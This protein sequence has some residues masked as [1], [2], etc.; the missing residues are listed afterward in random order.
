MDNLAFAI[1]KTILNG[2]ERHIYLFSEITQSAKQRFEQCQW[3]EVQVAAKARTDFYDQRVEETL[4]TLQ[5]DFFIGELKDDLWQAVK[6]SYVE[7]LNQHPQPELAE[8]FYN[9]VFCHL[10]ER[11]YYHNAYI[12][13][14]LK[15]AV[16]RKPLF[17]QPGLAGDWY[18]TKR[19]FQHPYRALF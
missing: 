5:Q 10:F 12:F 9:S 19:I 2:F 1:A 11:K 15:I 18:L 4:N 6:I 13:V 3:N 14:E 7:L 17:R 8:S 16:P